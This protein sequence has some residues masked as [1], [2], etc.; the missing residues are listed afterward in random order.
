MTTLTS[1]RATAFMVQVELVRK[2]KHFE[3]H[4]VTIDRYGRGVVQITTNADTPRIQKWFKDAG[5]Y[6]M[7]FDAN[8]FSSDGK[9][10]WLVTFKELAWKA[11][12]G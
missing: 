12:Y 7:Y 5:L 3:W 6:A 9:S 11:K 10:T 2:L 4:N 8:G 1:E